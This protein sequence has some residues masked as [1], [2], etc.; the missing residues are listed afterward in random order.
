MSLPLVLQVYVMGVKFNHLGE[1][2][3][4]LLQVR[5]V[6]L[7]R[8]SP[9]LGL[10]LETDFP[11]RVT[12]HQDSEEAT[13]SA[14]LSSP[15][16][17]TPQLLRP[18]LGVGGLGWGGGG[19]HCSRSSAALSSLETEATAQEAGPQP[20]AL[21]AG[22]F[23]PPGRRPPRLR[24]GAR[25]DVQSWTP[26]AL[27]SHEDQRRLRCCCVGR[28]VL[29]GGL[30]RPVR[31]SSAK[32]ARARQRPPRPG[33][34]ARVLYAFQQQQ[35]MNKSWGFVSFEDVA[36][37][38][39]WEEWQN[40]SDVQRTLYRDVMLETY[41]NLVSLG[42]CITKPEVIF[43]LEQEAEPWVIEEPPNQSL[44]D[45]QMFEGLITKSQES[46]GTDLWQVVIA[47][48]N[49]STERVESEKTFYLSSNCISNLIINSKNYSGLRCEE[50]NVC[51][52]AL[53]PRELDWMHAGVKS[54]DDSITE[55]LCQHCEH[56]NQHF[57]IQAEQQPFEYSGQG[58]TFSKEPIL[59]ANKKIHMGETS[60]KFDY[61]IEFHTSSVLAQEICPV[62]EKTFQCDVCWNTIY[63]KS[64]LTEHQKIHTAEKPYK[65]SECDKLFMKKLPLT[66]PERTHKGE[67]IYVCNECGKTFHRKSK[68]SRHQRTH[69]GEK[70][71]ECTECRKSFYRKSCLN[72][73][74][75]THTGEKPY[76]CSECGKTFQKKSNLS[77]HQ[78]T[79]TGKKPYECKE[80]K[81]S[82]Y[83]KSCL[84]VHERTHTG[85]KPYEC[86]ECGK[87]F[88]DKSHLSRHQR[89]HIGKKPYECKECR[90]CFYSKSQ[91]NIH[92]RIHTGEKPYSCKECRKSFYHNSDLN[93][94]K[95]VH[96]G[97]RPYECSECGK[98]FHWQSN[99]SKHQKIHTGMKPYECKECRKS[100][101]SKS[102][103]SVHQRTHTG[104]KPY[105]CEECRKSFYH[106]SDL[107]KHKK[108][109]TEERPYE[110]NECGKTFKHMSSLSKHQR[111]H[112]GEKPYACTECGK[113]FHKKSNL[114]K[115][116][117]IHTRGKPYE[118]KNV[119][120]LSTVNQTSVYIKE[121]TEV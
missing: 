12:N 65:C 115:H 44:Q 110:C 118:C 63:K 76:E 20:R 9:L 112:T 102:D 1:A 69:T 96:T 90:K 119:R 14:P 5:T 40:L 35:N 108:I 62:L 86:S 72:V 93:K 97:E 73:H 19:A 17:L 105:E 22:S 78:R 53:P 29:F 70:P 95:K 113:A 83:R 77:R 33:S 38:F 18:F 116:Q 104:E 52:N 107:N 4:T 121:L 82:F 58:S 81:K 92:Q 109:H 89:I 85:E 66:I 98:T 79:H 30:D 87:T 94:H 16:L 111:I 15:A 36:V 8:T 48:S 43:R 42:H 64:K 56:I 91:L 67:K 57:K 25:W 34:A 84:N 106:N 88:H 24:R 41:S 80:C 61:G 37:D 59:L 117:R 2:S 114:S 13:A 99:L 103:L 101:Y 31:R 46:H 71:Y 54:D 100:F 3:L 39:T 6:Y 26:P 45:A 60:C 27:T 11:S 7:S 21:A 23:G 10:E 49:T 68:L 75:R 28:E 47:N 74:E 55:K 32:G 120:K 51:W 50:C